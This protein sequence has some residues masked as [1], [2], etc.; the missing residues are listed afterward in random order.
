M[1]YA[2]KS[3]KQD[4]SGEQSASV[5]AQW[6]MCEAYAE[7][8]G[9]EVVA[10]EKDDGRSGLLD[11]TKRPGLDAALTALEEGQAQ[12]I[13]M[14][15]KSR[16]SR[17]ELD[18]ATMVRDFERQGIEW[19]AVADGGLVDRST[20]SGALKDGVD[21][22]FDTTYSIR[23][24]EN[25]K[26]AHA[27]CLDRGMPKTGNARFGY[28]REHKLDPRTKVSYPSGEFTQHETEALALRELYLR[29]TRGTG[30][31]PLVTWL[32]EEGHTTTR[33]NPW[34]VTALSRM[35][36]SGFGA[37]LISKEVKHRSMRG[38]HKPVITQDEWDAYL[39]A[40]TKARGKPRKAQAPRWYLAGIVKCGLCGG[41]TY[42]NSF[43][44]PTSSVE[45]SNHRANPDSCSG[46]MRAPRRW[47]E[48]QVTIW[49]GDHFDALAAEMPD[50]EAA[51]NEAQAAVDAARTALEATKESLVRAAGLLARNK[52]DEATFDGVKADLTAE[53]TEHEQSLAGAQERLLEVGPVDLDAL[54]K[55]GSYEG[56]PAEFGHHMSRVLKKL[57]VHPDSLAFHPVT[58]GRE[59]I[60]RPN[61]RAQAAREREAKRR[62]AAAV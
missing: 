25:W 29:Y 14:L 18:R 52:M 47:I 56:I 50:R 19:H 30:F 10:R 16:L 53:R 58:G 21:A 41:S 62:A 24:R 6:E 17:D 34:T 39:R 54:A 38:I 60:E 5:E 36:D 9:W 20:Y 44:S 33:G 3:T 28:K 22:L 45:C 11:R 7:D 37:G 26:A 51:A 40:R 61:L 35:M 48:T 31:T 49:F 8:R 57:E 13:V 15:W 59:K 46:K 42:I 2:R 43:E 1:I 4:R 32:N 23:V 27:R 55:I 12:G